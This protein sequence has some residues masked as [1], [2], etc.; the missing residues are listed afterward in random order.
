VVK[1]H[2]SEA[3]RIP[4]AIRTRAAIR[5]MEIVRRARIHQLAEIVPRPARIPPVETAPRH[6]LT[7]LVEIVHHAAISRVVARHRATDHRAPTRAVTT[8]LATALRVEIRARTTPAAIALNPPMATSG[9]IAQS[10]PRAP[11]AV[12]H[13]E[14]RRRVAARAV[15]AVDRVRRA[16]AIARETRNRCWRSNR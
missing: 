14:T 4:V 1:A 9:P 10:H 11:R 6:G 5:R 16:M 7:Q 8:P 2:R 15:D 3:T 12:L 13:E